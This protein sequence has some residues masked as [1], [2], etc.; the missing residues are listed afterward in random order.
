M[1]KILGGHG[2]PGYAYSNAS[3]A[4]RSTRV[5]WFLTAAETRNLF[6]TRYKQW[7]MLLAVRQARRNLSRSLTRFNLQFTGR[8]KIC[9]YRFHCTNLAAAEISQFV[10]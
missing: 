1:P 4:V 6:Q 10:L 7:Y 9:F 3:C 5:K 2:P 8:T